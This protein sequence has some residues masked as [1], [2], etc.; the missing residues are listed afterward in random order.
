MVTISERPMTRLVFVLDEKTRVDF[1]PAKRHGDVKFVFDCD[2]ERPS[3]WSVAYYEQ[4]VTKMLAQE[5]DPDVDYLVAVGSQVPLLLLSA[6]LV[7]KFGQVNLLLFDSTTSEY[8]H[9]RVAVNTE[10]STEE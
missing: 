4:A 6:T 1:S 8:V 7:A 3:I 9:K 10:L 2:D 5:F